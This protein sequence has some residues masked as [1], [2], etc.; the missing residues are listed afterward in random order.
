VVVLSQEIDRETSKR[1]AADIHRLSRDDYGKLITVVSCLGS[2]PQRAMTTEE[3][4]PG[5]LR[6]MI[7]AMGLLQNPYLIIM[8]E[9]T[10]HLDLPSIECM[11]NALEDCNAALLLV[12]HD[13]RFLQRLTDLCWKI[14]YDSVKENTESHL[15]IHP[16]IEDL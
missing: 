6:K 2:D 16:H 9:P 1:V 5:E 14:D 11:E 4:S 10:N 13:R 3:P 7:L 15:Q 12:S 8:D